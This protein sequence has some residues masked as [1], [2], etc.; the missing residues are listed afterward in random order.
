MFWRVAD[1]SRPRQGL[2]RFDVE[3]C[4]T[5]VR[6][7][8][9]R[10]LFLLLAL[11]AMNLPQTAVLCLGGDGHVAIELAGHDHCADGSH[12]HEYGPGGVK[13][14]D[15]SHVGRLDCRPC[16]DIPVSVGT[17]DTRRA[18]LELELAPVPIVGFQPGTDVQ[19]TSDTP[20]IATSASSLL[21][22]SCGTFLR[23]VVLQV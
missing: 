2:E 22:P 3:G 21:L 16:V 4:L 1:P 10:A 6:S 13:L 20:G 5:V 11:A 9:R 15:H 19:N 12:V 23:C 18:R 8:N 7:V 14:H 17:S